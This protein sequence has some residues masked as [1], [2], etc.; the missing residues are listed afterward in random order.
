MGLLSFLKRDKAAPPKKHSRGKGPRIVFRGFGAKAGMPEAGDTDR[1][2]AGWTTNPASI[3][4]IVEKTWLTMCARG[5]EAAMNTDHG[6]HFLRLFKQNVIG[7]KGIVVV[8]LVKG[9]DGKADTAARKALREAY[10]EWAREPEV[11]GTMTLREVD[12]LIAETVARDGEC[13]VRRL[14]GRRYGKFHY[15]LQL[16]DP[17]RVPVNYRTKLPNGNRVR[18]GIEFTAEGKPVAYYVRADMDDFVEA[19]EYS[20]TKYERIPASEIWHIFAPEFINQPRGLSWMG[21]ALTRLHHLSKFESAAVINAR[22]G[23]SKMGF[24]EPDPEYYDVD[25]DE[26]YNPEDDLPMDAEPGAFEGLPVGYRLKEWSPQYPHGDFEPFT[27]AVLHSV[28]AG[29]GV[30]FASLSGRLG[31]GSYSSNRSGEQTEQDRWIGIQSFFIEKL[32]QPRF[33]EFVSIAVLAGAVTIGTTPL[34]VE[35]VGQYKVARYQGRRWTW[36]DPS[37]DIPAHR[38]AQDARMRSISSSI[39][40]RG[41]DPDEV[42]EEIAEEREK[43]DAMGILPESKDSTGTTTTKA[44]ETED[45]EHAEQTE[46]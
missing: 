12:N 29:L 6:K 40:E 19:V 44:E 21:T 10:A 14:K 33:E 4:S 18:A 23:A 8:P 46:R 11:T 43:L 34:R 31:E 30:A 27:D 9:I 32:V 39:R 45:T 25:D 38:N 22:L 17:V 28:S 15:Q 3:L 26:D 13:F 24:F 5:R 7:P 41:E 20:G 2:T 1:L 16:I 42:F 35:R 37:K 36:W